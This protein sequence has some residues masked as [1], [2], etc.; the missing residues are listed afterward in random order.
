M[1][2]SILLF[3]ITPMSSL[4]FTTKLTLSQGDI[5]SKSRASFGMTICHFEP[6]FVVQH[7]LNIGLQALF[8]LI[9]S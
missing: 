7:S 5:L 4:S 8:L 3:G 2:V 9:I 1:R 6:I